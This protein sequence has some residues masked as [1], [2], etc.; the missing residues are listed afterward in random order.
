VINIPTIDLVNEAVGIGNSRGDKVDKF[1]GVRAH[2]SCWRKGGC[3]L[4]QG[5][6][7]ELRM[8]LGGWPPDLTIWSLHLG[9]G[10]SPRRGVPEVSGDPPLPWRRSIHGRRRSINLRNKF[11]PQNL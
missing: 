5:V 1:A 7:R 4:D 11:K 9:S 8:H 2:T 6:L 10:E 3:S